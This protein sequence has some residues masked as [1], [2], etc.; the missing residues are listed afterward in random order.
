MHKT[1]SVCLIAKPHKSMADIVLKTD[2][3]SL[4]S[5]SGAP[6][7]VHNDEHTLLSLKINSQHN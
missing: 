6:V 5:H 4:Q 3:N 2:T 1:F 7:Y